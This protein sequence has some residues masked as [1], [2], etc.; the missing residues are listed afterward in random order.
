MLTGFLRAEV[1]GDRLTREEILDICF[2]FL[3]AGLDT[4]TDSL[5]CFMAYLAQ[6]PEHR[7]EIVD[8]PSVIPSAVEELLRCETPVPGVARIVVQE[9]EI[10]G[11][12]TRGRRPRVHHDRR[13][14]LRTTRRSPI[15]TRS[16]CVASP[17]ATSPSG[18][19]CTAAWARTSRGSSCGSRCGNGTAASPST[20]SPT[21]WSSSTRR[22]CGKWSTSRSSSK[23]F[24]DD[25]RSSPG[26]GRP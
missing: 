6:H 19:A 23:R 15:P 2:L 7:Q 8:D 13:G 1:D 22:R 16:I 26:D 9:T 20:G 17:T 25:D 14:E 12:P 10:G 18:E 5:D 21:V 3:I 24:R 4:V 11:D